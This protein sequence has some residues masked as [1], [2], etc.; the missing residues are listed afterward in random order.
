MYGYPLRQEWNIP[1]KIADPDEDLWFT[2]ESGV[3]ECCGAEIYGPRHNHKEIIPMGSLFMVF[4]ANVMAILRCTELLLVNNMTVWR[5]HIHSDSR[6]ALVAFA[7]PLQNQPWCGNV[8]K[9]YKKLVN[10]IRSL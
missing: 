8:C 7:K 1:N 9:P 10:P 4:L 5:I 3:Y 6:A 2:D